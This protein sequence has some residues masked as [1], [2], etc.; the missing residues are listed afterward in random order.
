[1]NTVQYK[2]KVLSS[3]AILINQKNITWA[4][5]GSVLL[6]IKGLVDDFN[7][8]DILVIEEDV[9]SLKEILLAHG[10]LI[11][12]S[13][14][15]KY[16]TKHFYEFVIDGVDIDII[17]GFTIV[18]KEKAYYFPLKS[19]EILEFVELNKVIIPLHSI[20]IWRIYYE[21]MG[22]SEKVRIIDD[23]VF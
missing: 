11:N 15:S 14:N 1:M 22:R 23:H 4:I 21:L 6:Y 16:Q 3:L 10:Q 20:Q 8:I 5:G 19:D 7:D 18:D 13:L 17:A 12:H 2:L 9:E